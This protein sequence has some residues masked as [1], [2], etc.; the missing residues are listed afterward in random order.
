MKTIH[1]IRIDII[2]FF[3]ELAMKLIDRL[4]SDRKKAWKAWN[5]T[6]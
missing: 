1:R 6:V 3:C 2:D 5:E 4:E